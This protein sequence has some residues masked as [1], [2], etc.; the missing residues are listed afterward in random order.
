[1]VNRVSELLL[2]GIPK[3]VSTYAKV[4]SNED[5]IAALLCVR[6]DD[7]RGR[8][9]DHTSA[10]IAFTSTAPTRAARAG[11]NP[12]GRRGPIPNRR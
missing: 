8:S 7:G 11:R 6:R 1:M 5:E 2:D 10:G 4:D 3:H 9:G 12:S